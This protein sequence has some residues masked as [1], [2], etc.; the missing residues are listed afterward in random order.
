MLVIKTAY[1]LRPGGSETL[2]VPVQF[3]VTDDRFMSELLHYQQNTI[4]SD[5]MSDS[6]CSSGNNGS[7]LSAESD[8]EQ[9]VGSKSTGVDTQVPST[10]NDTGGLVSDTVSQQAIN[11]QI[12]AQLRSISKCLD[13]I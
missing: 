8:T 10:W 6:D 7:M 12:L 4:N 1:N 11:L 5:Q 2:S 3:Q 9:T 13:A